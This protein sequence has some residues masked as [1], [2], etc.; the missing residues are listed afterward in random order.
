[1]NMNSYIKV[2]GVAAQVTHRNLD[3]TYLTLP[4]G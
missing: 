3:I 4:N 1:M 2:E